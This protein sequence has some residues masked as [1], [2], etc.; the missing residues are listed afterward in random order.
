MPDTI[1]LKG[2]QFHALVGVYPHEAEFAQP[3]EVDLSVD[4]AT[5]ASAAIVDYTNLYADVASVLTAGHIGY[6]EEVAERI[7][8]RVLQ[9]PGI[10]TVHIS[11]RKPHVALPGPLAYAEI[12]ITR[13]HT[14]S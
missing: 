11:V 12:S 5:V 8:T 1:T 10:Q 14:E 2:M 3:I 6:L 13:P 9:R 7:A 4:L